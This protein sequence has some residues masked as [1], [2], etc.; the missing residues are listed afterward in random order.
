M[1]PHLVPL[2]K[3]CDW[4]YR[5]HIPV[6]NEDL[7][8]I[9][10][11]MD[12]ERWASVQ[13]AFIE[14]AGLGTSGAMNSPQVHLELDRS[15]REIHIF[16]TSTDGDE[17][18]E[19][20]LRDVLPEE[21]F[22]LTAPNDVPPCPVCAERS[23]PSLK[24]SCGHIYCQHCY[25]LLV[26]SQDPPLNCIGDNNT[27]RTKW[28]VQDIA[29]KLLPSQLERLI[30]RSVRS[31]VR[32]SQNQV[33]ECPTGSCRT[34]LNA[35]VPGLQVCRGCAFVIYTA[36]KSPNHIGRS[37]KEFRKGTEE[38][39]IYVDENNHISE[40]KACPG[41]GTSVERGDG[42]FHIFCTACKTNF[43]FLC[44]ETFPNGPS[45]YEHMRTAHEGGGVDM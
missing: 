8:P 15:R 16:T 6:Y 20:E 3:L 39:S 25:R 37:C 18:V 30:L 36:C 7:V 4:S 10:E 26:S 22:A 35:Q 21:E 44:L 17:Q 11:G 32:S 14:A 24:A 9:W 1:G 43:C 23:S 40:I 5:G 42:C 27:C 31:F 2:R 41:C 33:F 38:G 12:A 34:I 13:A 45:V 29:D 19:H 28:P